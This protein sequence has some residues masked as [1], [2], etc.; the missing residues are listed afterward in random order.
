MTQETSESKIGCAIYCRYSSE[1]QRDNMSIEAQKH[2]C[3]EFASKQGWRVHKIYVDEARSGSSDDREFF[4]Q[5]ISESIDSRHPVNY[6][7][8]HKLDRFAR[9]RYD[10]IKYKHLLR[11]KGVKV[12][13]A[14]QPI[15][16]SGDPTEVLLEA[17]LEGMDEFYSLN[18]ARESIKGMAENARN[19]WWNGGL[20][21]IG[22]KL[23]QI[24]T[25]KGPKRKLEVEDSEAA[26]IRKI[27]S[28]YLKRNGVSKI[29]NLLNAEG[30]MARKRRFAKNLILD[31]L[32]NEKY[33]G[34]MTFGKRMNKRK[35]PIDV[36]MEPITVRNTHEPLIPRDD[37]NK[38]QSML[39]EKRTD[40]R[41]PRAIA[42][43][44]LFSGLIECE[45]CGSKFVGISGYNARKRPYRYYMCNQARRM[46]PAQCG[47]RKFNADTLEPVLINRLK[48]HLT[49]PE[50]ITAIVETHNDAITKLKENAPVRIARI[51]KEIKN[52]DKRI[53]KLF[54]A[55]ETSDL[56]LNKEDVAPRFRELK[57]K[58]ISLE[59][60]LEEV[61]AKAHQKRVT[62]SEE[63]IAAWVDLYDNLLSDE[64]VWVKKSVL[65]SCIESV[66][67][68]ND[69]ARMTCDPSFSHTGDSVSLEELLKRPPKNTP[70]PPPAGAECSYKMI[71]AARPGFEPRTSPPKGG[72][73]PLHHRAIKQ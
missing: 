58:K 55:I 30:L 66:K 28:L 52:I 8:V 64:S 57:A 71:V 54:E 29:R 63:V 5:M 10:S 42:S 33:V 41:H 70:L 9:N 37:W 19:G 62:V 50:T 45:T 51:E 2:A 25:P 61:K 59:I 31:I 11:K 35:N 38:V 23:I 34:D 22:Y 26:L 12:I 48:E 36:K 6:V 13:S 16:G 49:T 40:L 47:Q 65:R 73:L 53:A 56:G 15:I 18:L 43:T 14:S 7:L 17:M 21:P 3:I 32:R 20:A 24:Q 44:Y 39:A 68:G 69:G 72:V 46:G 60:E 27:Y 67:I 4:Q 1:Q